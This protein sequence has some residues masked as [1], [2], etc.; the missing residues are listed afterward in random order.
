MSTECADAASVHLSPK[1][2]EQPGILP[3]RMGQK[4]PTMMNPTGPPMPQKSHSN[5]KQSV[6]IVAVDLESVHGAVD[7]AP[8]VYEK[9]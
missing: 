2:P 1:P 7:T 8:N 4:F 3:M 5:R 6:Q 9:R